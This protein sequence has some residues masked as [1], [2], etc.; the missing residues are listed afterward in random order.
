MST[1]L[2]RN[3]FQKKSKLKKPT[4]VQ[5]VESPVSTV[6]K[7]GAYAVLGGLLAISYGLTRIMPQKRPLDRQKHS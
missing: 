4:L 7:V 3:P 5:A 2:G 6:A 1:K